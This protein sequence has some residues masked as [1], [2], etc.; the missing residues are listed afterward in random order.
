MILGSD[1]SK[2]VPFGSAPFDLLAA[3]RTIIDASH[4]FRD[5]GY[6]DIWIYLIHGRLHFSHVI[7]PL[8]ASLFI[9][10]YKIREILGSFPVEKRKSLCAALAI[11]F[12]TTQN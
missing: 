3:L 2:P 4:K 10:H 5:I 12:Y 8:P 9:A 11:V 1:M 6:S 7:L